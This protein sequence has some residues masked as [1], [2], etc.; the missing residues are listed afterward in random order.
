MT[1]NRSSL[2]EYFNPLTTTDKQALERRLE[3]HRDRLESQGFEVAVAEAENGFF[4]AVLVIDD[5]TDRFGFLEP[6][7][8]VAWIAGQEQGIGALG[9]AVLQNPTEKLEQD[10]DG[11]ENAEIE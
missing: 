10:V 6:D 11:L 8:S 4:A 9:S 1:N 2:Q 5:R 7:G 3:E